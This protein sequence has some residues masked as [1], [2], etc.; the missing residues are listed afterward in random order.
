LGC[1]FIFGCYKA[2]LV[3]IASAAAV[4]WTASVLW[5]IVLVLLLP[6][7]LYVIC[8]GTVNKF[9]TLRKQILFTEEE[10]LAEGVLT[11]LVM[12]ITITITTV[13]W[14]GL[15]YDPTGTF[16]PDWTNKLG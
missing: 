13:L 11:A 5:E 6:A 8:G 16:K 3:H 1:G 12:F 4:G 2:F 14:Y 7:I 9:S 10:S 15:R